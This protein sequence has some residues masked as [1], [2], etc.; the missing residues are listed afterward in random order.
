MM[1]CRNTQAIARYGGEKMQTISRFFIRVDI[2]MAA[3]YR[4]PSSQASNDSTANRLAHQDVFFVPM[5]SEVN[6]SA[7]RNQNPL[8]SI[9]STTLNGFNFVKK[10]IDLGPLHGTGVLP[11]NVEE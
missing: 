9:P 5:I 1:Q 3:A 7:L 11:K 8:S 6:Y 2:V 4:E 10:S